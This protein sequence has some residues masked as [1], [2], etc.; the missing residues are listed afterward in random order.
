MYNDEM[1]AA[2]KHLKNPVWLLR[3][4]IYGLSC[5]GKLWQQH[6]EDAVTSIGWKRVPDQPQCFYK[7]HAA[8]RCLM[9]VYVDDVVLG[10]PKHGLLW[11]ELGRAVELTK[12]EP[13]SRV[14]GV[15]FKF[16]KPSPNKYK[17]TMEM[18]EYLADAVKKYNEAAAEV[19]GPALSKSAAAPCR[20]FAVKDFTDPAM[21]CQGKFHKKCASLLMTLLYPGRMC[22]PDIVFGVTS[23]ARFVSCWTV[24][25]DI[26]LCQ[27]FSYVAATVNLTHE[28][29]V[30]C[31]KS[32]LSSLTLSAFPDADLAGSDDST[33]STSGGLL[34]VNTGGVDGDDKCTFIIDYWT[35]RQGCTSHSSTESELVSLE[36]C[37][38]EHSIPAQTMWEAFLSR[39]VKVY[40]WEDNQS[41]IAIIR[42]G[43]SVAMR[44][45]SKC[46]RIS[47]GALSEHFQ[48]DSRPLGHISTDKQKGDPMTKGLGTKKHSD[49]LLML[50]MT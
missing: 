11:E 19:G 29:F 10:G 2:A 45:L 1:A 23:A 24:M 18:K 42:A 37:C 28:G 16:S 22:R 32:S 4:P 17:V 49:A 33:K 31:S 26:R 38:R 30:C 50:Q 47:V 36:K 21:Q 6:F 7:D 41:C 44:H 14:L 13:L 43:F 12:P 8:G 9:C 27:L 34:E 48:D 40:H 39:I 5:S 25:S 3:R 46:H 20:D 35:K 15:N